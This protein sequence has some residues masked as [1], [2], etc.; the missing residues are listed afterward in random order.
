VRGSF[1]ANIDFS[2]IALP[3]QLKNYQEILNLIVNHDTEGAIEM[4]KNL[5]VREI[6]GI[7][8]LN[9]VLEDINFENGI[10]ETL[11]WNPLHFAVYFQNLELVKY[12]IKDLRV[13]LGLTAPKSNAETEKD[14]VNTD[15]YPEDKLMTLLLAY[16]R[17]D[18]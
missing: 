10:V 18:P 16:D 6:V 11:M 4:I 2:N 3:S 9:L 5:K 14:P 8:G 17:K 13:N 7:R 15:R 12:F 1:L